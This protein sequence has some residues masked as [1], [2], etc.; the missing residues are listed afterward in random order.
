MGSQYTRTPDFAPKKI[1]QAAFHSQ[2]NLWSI[3]S[4]QAMNESEEL[5]AAQFIRSR[6][7]KDD[8][9]A[10]RANPLPG[11]K[12]LVLDKPDDGDR[13]GWIN[14]A[15]RRL[16]IKGDIS[17]NNRDIVKPAGIGQALHAF[18]QLKECFGFVRISKV[19][20]VSHGK[21]RG[22]GARKVAQTLHHC[23]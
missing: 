1:G 17:T 3:A 20:V 22:T 23:N 16:V 8:L 10:R 18:F 19:K 14:R 2:I 7:Q 5:T 13:R 15:F 12:A 9:I 21:R 11:D 4:L 6:T